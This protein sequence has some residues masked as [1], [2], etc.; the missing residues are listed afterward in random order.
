LERNAELGISLHVLKENLLPAAIIK[1]C[2]PAI[3]VASDPLGSFQGD[4]IF[5][6]VR[7]TGCAE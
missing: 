4:V 5:Q 3:G 6:K 7:D 2:G 1:L